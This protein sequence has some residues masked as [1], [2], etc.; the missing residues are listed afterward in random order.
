MAAVRVSMVHYN[1]IA[2]VDRLHVDRFWRR[3]GVCE[4]L[5]CERQGDGM[6]RFDTIIKNGTVVT[7]SD[8]FV[9][10][11]GIRDG[12]LRHLPLT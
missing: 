2:E 12:R 5:S 8:T 3:C 6:M 11:V 9:S 1:T 4:T 10:D 7:A